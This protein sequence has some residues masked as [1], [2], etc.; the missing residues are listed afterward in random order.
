MSCGS[1]FSLFGKLIDTVNCFQG[2]RCCQG[3]CCNRISI[4]AGGDP[5]LAGANPAVGA[6]SR[7][8]LGGL[9]RLAEEQPRRD[10]ASLYPGTAVREKGVSKGKKAL[11][12]RYLLPPFAFP[13]SKEAGRGAVLPSAL[14]EDLIDVLSGY[15]KSEKKAREG[16]FYLGRLRLEALLIY[17][18]TET[19]EME[20][21][22][23][24]L[25]KQ[26]AG[27]LEIDGAMAFLFALLKSER[28]EERLRSY[29]ITA[30]ML[31]K[32]KA[33]FKKS[34]FSEDLNQ[35]AVLREC[36]S[37][38]LALLMEIASEKNWRKYVDDR[39]GL[40]NWYQNGFE[41]EPACAGEVVLRELEGAASDTRAEKAAEEDQESVVGLLKKLKV[42]IFGQ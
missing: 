32:I 37:S 25:R 17:T 30:A 23:E 42:K 6:I 2:M 26:A 3:G 1:I 5:R 20:A 29:H 8:A 19:A 36:S 38:T 33:A 31:E 11:E 16:L 15:K 27:L 28:A 39:Y 7:S 18:R 13:G 4:E 35:A 24:A 9:P 10:S 22:K 40:K 41:G 34:I 14:Q 21:K 12:R